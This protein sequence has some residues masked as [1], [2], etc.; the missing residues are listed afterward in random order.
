MAQPNNPVGQ[1]HRIAPEK[2]LAA[3]NAHFKKLGIAPRCVVCGNNSWEMGNVIAP[4]IYATNN[5]LTIGGPV[6]PVVPMVCRNC[7]NTIQFAAGALGLLN[8]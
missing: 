6:V 7:G 2:V 5:A 3:L 4:P 1:T 8:P